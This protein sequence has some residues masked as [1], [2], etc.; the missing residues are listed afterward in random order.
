LF[1]LKKVNSPSRDI[2]TIDFGMVNAYLVRARDGFVLIDTGL[3]RHWPLLERSLAAA[4]A[5]P[6][7]IKL[8]VITHGDWDHTG[9]CVRLRRE[10]RAPLALHPGDL[11]MVR[12]GLLPTRTVRPLLFKLL[13]AAISLRRHGH[14]TERFVPDILLAD[15]Q[16]L[17]QYGLAARVAHIPGH[18]AGSI[19]IIT[20]DGALFPGDTMTNRRKPDYA[21]F[22]EDRTA[23]RGS[24]KTLQALDV[25]M[26]Y[27]GHGRPFGR[28]E[29]LKIKP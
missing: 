16:R 29:L 27:P 3:P 11:P 10:Y 2:T 15:G 13:Y 6:G 19:A 4:G 5:L 23:L 7:K 14:D 25:K 26:V 22:I 21:A 9:N 12:D 18:T 1:I 17:D 8:V 28:A 20:D 24:I